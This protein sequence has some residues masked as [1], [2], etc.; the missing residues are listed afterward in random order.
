MVT[1][2]AHNLYMKEVIMCCLVR[3]VDEY[4]AMAKL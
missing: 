3:A 2:E 4:D 1:V